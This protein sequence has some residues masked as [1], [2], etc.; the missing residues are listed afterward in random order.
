MKSLILFLAFCFMTFNT[1][2]ADINIV[3]V[4]RNIPLSDEDPIYKDFF[5]NAGEGSG[6]KK[7]LV[8]NVKRRLSIK[9]ANAKTVGDFETTVGQLR[10]LQVEG[11]VAIAREY[12]LFSRDEEAMIEQIGIMTGDRVD[13]TGAFTDNSKPV[14]KKN[15]AEVESEA[16]REP[17]SITTP[18]PTVKESP[19]QNAVP[20]QTPE[21]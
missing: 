11:K 5:L 4:K 7:N 2:A 18:A 1:S 15:V 9:D 6:L 13:L 19:I 10:I 17:A 12:K 20:L 14:V 16:T 21:I 3:D 8:V